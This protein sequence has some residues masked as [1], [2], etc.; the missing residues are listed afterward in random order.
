MQVKYLRL[1]NYDRWPIGKTQCLPVPRLYGHEEFTDALQSKFRRWRRNELHPQRAKY[2]L[3]VRPTDDER[4]VLAIIY[5]AA[6]D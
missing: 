6:P 1:P 3:H 5:Q 2:R 4:A